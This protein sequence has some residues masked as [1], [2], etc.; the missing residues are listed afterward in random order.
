MVQIACGMGHMIA[1]TMHGGLLQWGHTGDW[2][3]L[4][5]V[6]EKRRIESV[7]PLPRTIDLSLEAYAG[8]AAVPRE[9]DEDEDGHEV[10]EGARCN[11]TAAAPDP[12]LPA[13]GCLAP[14]ALHS[15]ELPTSSHGLRPAASRRLEAAAL[16]AG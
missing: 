1:R 13:H 8:Y 15:L 10:E 5:E 14:P 12:P 16:S 11:A 3:K 2:R 9:G 4:A 6:E 7:H